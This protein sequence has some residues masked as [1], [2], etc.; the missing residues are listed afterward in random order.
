MSQMFVIVVAAIVMI[1][2]MIQMGRFVIVVVIIIIHMAVPR[3]ECATRG[4][5]G[6][7]RGLRITA[8][9]APELSQDVVLLVDFMIRSIG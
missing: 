1:R 8:A 7:G 2:M 9:A 3:K 6:F 5:G 4:R